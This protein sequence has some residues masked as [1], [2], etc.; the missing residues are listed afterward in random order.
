MI[1][2]PDR[3]KFIVMGVVT[4]ILLLAVFAWFLIATFPGYLFRQEVFSLFSGKGRERGE[5]RFAER[6]R[7]LGLH[8]D[9]LA[10]RI[11]V[12][13]GERK[14]RLKHADIT[15]AEF[16]VGI[17]PNSNGHKK[18]EGDGHTPEGEYYVCTKNESSRFHLFLGLSYPSPADGAR[19][20][21][22]G[23]ITATESEA[24]LDAWM[25][26]ARPPWGTPLGGVIGIHGFGG[27]RDW[28]QGCIALNNGDIE[29]LFWNVQTGTP[30][31]IS[32]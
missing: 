17:G 32:P 11:E 12:V 7:A 16:P 9:A 15:I 30:V 24:I 6:L 19:A 25:K 27:N 8:P 3:I 23:V 4:I 5:A 13:K 26:R 10:L 18:I 14:L 22:E 21:S 28:T 2:P 29:E 31:I 20:L 1:F